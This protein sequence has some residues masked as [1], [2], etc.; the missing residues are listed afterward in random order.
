MEKLRK[1]CCPML[2]IGIDTSTEMGAIGLINDEELL[3]EIN[4]ALYRQHSKRLLPNIRYMLKEADL[5]I[6]DVEGI[7][8]TVG[9]GSYT[10]LRIGLST[11]KAFA[12][13]LNIPVVALSTL[14]V[15]AYNLH[16]S[17]SWL[18]PV[19]DARR[20]RVYTALYRGG[21]RDMRAS[22][23]WE[24]RVMAVDELLS[25]L[26]ETADDEEIFLLGNGVPVYR[27]EFN[28]SNLNIIC[29]AEEFNKPRGGVV[30]ALGQYYLKQGESDNI[31]KI[32]PNYLKKPQAEVNFRTGD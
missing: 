11:V 17:N 6:Q 32:L 27:E 3:A 5:E 29:A 31:I 9:P 14:A 21:S 15:V 26:K 30:A 4:I 19:I 20:Q 16:Y 28:N 10:G 1:G 13:A 12:Q 18:V 25:K 2:T 7:A 22:Q 24:D 8:I 23:E